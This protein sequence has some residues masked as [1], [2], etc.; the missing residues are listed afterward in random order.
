MRSVPRFKKC[1]NIKKHTESPDQFEAWAEWEKE[2]R[3]THVNRPCWGCGLWIMWEP[4][5]NEGELDLI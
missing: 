3:K 1:P 4:K 2:K 5:E